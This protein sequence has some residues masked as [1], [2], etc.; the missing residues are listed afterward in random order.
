MMEDIEPQRQHG[1]LR[2]EAADWFA[3]MRNPD[4]PPEVRDEFEKWLARGALH[5]AAYSRIAETYS[6]GKR[7]KDP[8]DDIASDS[9]AGHGRDEI[10]S[11]RSTSRTGKR[12]LMLIGTI[13]AIAL[14][15][16]WA[17]SSPRIED[18]SSTGIAQTA[19]QGETFTKLTTA[20]GEVRS[21]NLADGSV[22]TLDTDS[23]V[24]V[25]YDNAVRM[26][27]LLRGRARFSVAHEGRSFVV[28]AGSGTVLARGTVFDVSLLADNRV[29]VRLLRGSV[30]VSSAAVGTGRPES[31]LRLSPGE[32]V[33][34]QAEFPAAATKVQPSKSDDA[35]WPE[36]FREFSEIRLQDLFTEANRYARIP[37]V[38]AT[39][40]IADLKVSGRLRIV[41]SAR[42]ARNLGDLLGL[43][44]LTEPNA[45]TLLRRCPVPS[46]ENCRPS[47]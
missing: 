43:A 5:R 3:I 38:A 35:N 28:K 42:L 46:K 29:I 44:V 41:D 6:I 39:P 20:A 36:G 30:D 18:Q 25:R 2:E 21:F 24:L 23:L 15:S 47:S 14:I 17:M 45:I 8:P 33:V 26:L 12:A 40:D 27:E 34:L 4:T 13:A 22:I 32:Q 10:Q 16:H 19:A 7:L 1:Q 37:L 31:T 9:I 11:P